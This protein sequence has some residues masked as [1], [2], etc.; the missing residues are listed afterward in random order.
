MTGIYFDFEHVD[1]ERFSFG[2]DP[3]DKVIHTKIRLRRVDKAR[4]RVE[5][6]MLNEPLGLLDLALEYTESGNYKEW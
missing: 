1:F 4:F 2:T 6:D 5:N 3:T